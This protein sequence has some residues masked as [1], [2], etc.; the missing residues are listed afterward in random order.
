MSP[1]MHSRC[2]A[3]SAW[4]ELLS[5]CPPPGGQSKVEMGP[6]E[7]LVSW[8]SRVYIPPP[9]WGLHL[10]QQIN[11]LMIPG[12]LIPTHPRTRLQAVS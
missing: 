6:E 3:W 7:E 12:P 10:H 8:Y 2:W 9:E 11:P 1:V 4:E 5:R